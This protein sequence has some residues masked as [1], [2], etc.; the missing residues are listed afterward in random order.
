[1]LSVLVML[2]VLTMLTILMLFS[3]QS[4]LYLND[5][6]F[7]LHRMQRRHNTEED[8]FILLHRTFPAVGQVQPSDLHEGRPV[9][10]EKS[11]MPNALLG[12][13]SG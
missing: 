13:E 10:R 11:V 4:F 6:T 9:V 8:M 7:F 1:M 2:N 5:S 12:T 3:L